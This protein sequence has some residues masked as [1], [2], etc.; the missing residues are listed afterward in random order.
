MAEYSY[1]VP[2]SKS[3][4]FAEGAAPG[5]KFVKVTR[6][7]P[8]PVVAQGIQR[9]KLGSSVPASNNNANRA[10]RPPPL[11][12]PWD[13]HLPG[14]FDREKFWAWAYA[15]L[16]N[17]PNFVYNPKLNM[18][19]TR[20]QNITRGRV[21]IQPHI[22]Y[23]CRVNADVTFWPRDVRMRDPWERFLA[24]MADVFS[25]KTLEAKF[26]EAMRPKLVEYDIIMKTNRF[27]PL[28]NAAPVWVEMC[29]L[30]MCIA[31]YAEI[32]YCGVNL[33]VKRPV[34]FLVVKQLD[35]FE[36][37]SS[38][39]SEYRGNFWWVPM[40]MCLPLRCAPMSWPTPG[41]GGDFQPDDVVMLWEDGFARI[42]PL[43]YVL[44]DR[45][46]EMVEARSALF[47]QY[48][49]SFGLINIPL[50]ANTPEQEARL[51]RFSV[52]RYVPQA[53]AD[54]QESE[55]ATE[56]EEEATPPETDAAPVSAT[57]TSVPTTTAPSQRLLS[58]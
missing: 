22:E 12:T 53:D 3:D 9:Y 16:Y 20:L 5:T 37:A 40:A 29:K 47:A 15:I 30:G 24:V 7:T 26:I 2:T 33:D 38:F 14:G 55:K 44:Q 10:P 36:G 4:L 17:P 21:V 11:P 31:L 43:Q 46:R 54:K 45:S 1:V 28:R 49:E 51:G 8:S 42:A 52:V 35:P 57:P 56:E 19:W 39:R 18:G 23:H 34:P 27:I 25:V 50:M 13:Y 41:R 48:P 6:T 58:W 32:V